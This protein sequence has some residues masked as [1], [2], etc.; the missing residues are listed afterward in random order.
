MILDSKSSDLFFHTYGDDPERVYFSHGRLELLGNHT[1]HNH[2][3][4]LVGGVDMGI[5]ASVKKSEGK[6]IMILS[7]GYPTFEVDLDHLEIDKKEYGTSKA[8]V[9]GVCFR[10]KELGYAIGGFQAACASDIFPGAGVSS[11]AAY[12]SLIIEILN[13]LY[14]EGKITPLEMAKIGQYAENVYFGK[15]SGL[16]DQVGSSFGGVCY[17]DFK[18]TQSPIVESLPYDFPF[19]VVLVNSGGSHAKLTPLYASIPNDMYAVAANMFGKKVLREVPQ[20]EF[21]RKIGTPCPG[22]SE[23]AK[24]RAQ[25]FYDENARVLKARQA[26]INHDQNSFLLSVS[27]S[28]DSS[29]DFLHNTMVPGQYE[30]SPQQAVDI[31]RRYIGKGAV[32]IMGGGFAGSIIAF[33]YPTDFDAFMAEMIGHYG[34]KNVKEVKILSGGPRRI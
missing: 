23:I 5:T 6:T 17:I 29:R 31:A 34:K 12:E 24:L 14:N 19:R 18:S 11:S 27:E 13:D 4:C 10:L 7:E 3:L 20:E 26:I 22:V 30:H 2:G 21:M 16:L 28:G 25:H 8:I 1:D 32:R 15:P 9:K 33:V